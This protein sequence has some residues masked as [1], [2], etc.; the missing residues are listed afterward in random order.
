[1]SA[2]TQQGMN[3][4]MWQAGLQSQQFPFTAL[5]GMMGGTYGQPVVQQG[6]AGWQGA[7]MG[8]MAGYAA[9]NSPWGAA[10]GAYGGYYS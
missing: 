8:G 6:N 5:P 7:A 9:T 2:Q 3:Q 4:N 10:A 1:M